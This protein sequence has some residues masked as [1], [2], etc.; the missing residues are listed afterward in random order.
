MFSEDESRSEAPSDRSGGSDGHEE[1]DAFVRKWNEAIAS[2]SA[3]EERPGKANFKRERRLSLYDRGMEG[4]RRKEAKAMERRRE[5]SAQDAEEFT[6]SPQISKYVRKRPVKDPKLSVEERLLKAEKEKKT[7]IREMR[8]VSIADELEDCTFK[9]NINAYKGPVGGGKAGTPSSVRRRAASTPD[10]AALAGMSRRDESQ[11]PDEVFDRLWDDSRSKQVRTKRRKASWRRRESILPSG[12]PLSPFALNL[13]TPP[14]KPKKP[15]ARSRVSDLKMH[16]EWINN[17][18]RDASVRRQVQREREEAIDRQIS[19]LTTCYNMTSHSF[20]LMMKT[21]SRQTTLI[22]DNLFPNSDHATRGRFLDLVIA[23]EILPPLEK[24]GAKHLKYLPEE[25]LL[26][27]RLWNVLAAQ[28]DSETEGVVGVIPKV[29]LHDFMILVECCILNGDMK[30]EMRDLFNDKKSGESLEFWNVLD[31]VAEMK[32]VNKQAYSKL[33]LNHGDSTGDTGIEEEEEREEGKAQKKGRKSF[34]KFYKSQISHPAKVKEKTETLRAKLDAEE[35]SHCT[36][37]PKLNPHRSAAPS[38]FRPKIASTQVSIVKDLKRA[39]TPSKALVPRASP[40]QSSPRRDNHVTFAVLKYPNGYNKHLDR[41]SVFTECDPHCFHYLSEK[42][43]ECGLSRIAF[44]LEFRFQGRFVSVPV[45]VVDNP[46]IIALFIAKHLAIPKEVSLGD[47]GPTSL[48]QRFQPLTQILSLSFSIHQAYSQLISI[49]KNKMVVNGCMESYKDA[50]E[51]MALTYSY[52]D[53]YVRSKGL[54]KPWQHLYS[55]FDHDRDGRS[56]YS[57]LA[58]GKGGPEPLR[59]ESEFFSKALENDDAEDDR[60]DESDGSDA[61]LPGRARVEASSGQT[62]WQESLRQPMASQNDASAPSYSKLE[63]MRRQKSGRGGGIGPENSIKEWREDPPQGHFERESSFA[64][65]V[66]DPGFLGH[67]HSP[68]R[69][70]DLSVYR[71]E[72]QAALLTEP[73]EAT[74]REHL[75]RAMEDMW[76]PMK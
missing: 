34:L 8:R 65:M 21:V 61:A 45:R 30:Q 19:N 5:E 24:L 55:V 35:R 68:Q 12:V 66:L 39:Q 40:R 60:D 10:A 32:L 9:P 73:P 28:V 31:Q 51:R 64:K 44:Y 48:P 14:P 15:A 42:E 26:V 1:G 56:S 72:L 11:E 71:S 43:R 29:A 18:Y 53:Q 37:A 2:T 74:S 13:R 33:R 16:S 4:L 7:A 70:G 6:F 38:K 3:Q 22:L 46:R 20:N 75:V 25:E 27:E 50:D 59:E 67:F 57:S 69:Q 58:Y 47:L 54:Q 62:T 36:F 23:L 17:L 63:G 49:V 52:A 41:M 76:L